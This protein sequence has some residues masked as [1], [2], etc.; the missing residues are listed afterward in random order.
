MALFIIAPAVSLAVAYLFHLAFER[1]PSI[2]G[3]PKK[4]MP[5][6]DTSPMAEM[7]GMRRLSA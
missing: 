6:R 4:L 3:P 1:Q 7:P 5:L 2:H